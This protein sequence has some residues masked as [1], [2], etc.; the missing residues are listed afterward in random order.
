MFVPPSGRHHAL[1]PW[2]LTQASGINNGSQELITLVDT[3][4]FLRLSGSPDVTPLHRPFAIITKNAL[5]RGDT[6][7]LYH[8]QASIV[9]Q[10]GQH[11]SIFGGFISD[12]HCPSIEVTLHFALGK[13]L[14]TL[15][16]VRSVVNSDTP[17]T[18]GAIIQR[19][20]KTP[21]AIR[22]YWRGDGYT[23]SRIYEERKGVPRH[24]LDELKRDVGLEMYF[25]PVETSFRL[26]RTLS[27][28]DKQRATV[29]SRQM[30]HQGSVSAHTTLN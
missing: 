15:I 21:G 12:P 20:L 30:G 8:G 29:I 7:H 11:N 18:I 14:P 26:N 9:Q 16:D 19:S 17:L 5:Q 28:T 13:R 22:I 23:A 27:P 2:S 3:N 10:I 24:L 4:P 1:T 6:L 25:R